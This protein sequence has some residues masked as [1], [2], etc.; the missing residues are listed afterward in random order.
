V[1]KPFN[2]RGLGVQ[3]LDLE[4]LGSQAASP[5]QPSLASQATSYQASQPGSLLRK[6][7]KLLELLD[8]LKLFGI[9]LDFMG[10]T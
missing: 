3:P 8:F 10:F 9:L 4:I 7:S 1:P 5:A 6:P 2:L